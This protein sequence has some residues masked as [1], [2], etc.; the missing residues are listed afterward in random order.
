ML[1]RGSVQD[2]G[3]VTILLDMTLVDHLAEELGCS[4]TSSC[5]LLQVGHA[6]PQFLQFLFIGS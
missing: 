3:V 6:D 4:L 1:P 2:D 5:L